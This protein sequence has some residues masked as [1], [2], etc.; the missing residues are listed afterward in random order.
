MGGASAPTEA[1]P[2]GGWK[3]NALLNKLFVTVV[4]L[5]L[6]AYW[7]LPFDVLVW[8]GLPRFQ[9]GIE[10]FFIAGVMMVLGLVW[11]LITNAGVIVGP[12]VALCARLPGLFIL[13]RL[14]SSYP[15]QR[16]FRT[17]LSVVMFSLVVFAMTVM[18]VITNAMQN[19][20]TNIDTQTGG[21]DIQAV[22]YFKPLPDLRS[23][24]LQ[25]GIN[26]NV[27]SAIGVST[28]TAIGVIQPS[29]DRPGWRIYPAQ[30][31]NG[32]FL[33]GYGVHLLARAKGFASDEAVW[34]ALQTHAN[35]ALIDSNALPYR[36]DSVLNSPVYDPN[37]PL[38]ADAG[39]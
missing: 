11:V 9:G 4:G 34:Q 29:S 24:L 10:G 37:S 16:R 15:L 3:V 2:W 36:P 25:H 18:A 33:Q 39:A 27:F 30:I 12:L 32:G 14:A 28:S 19:T 26:P 1:K 21:Y 17:G 22:A 7:A 5:V 38:P 13:S 6:V 20:Y 35:Y 8:L 23:A 31:V